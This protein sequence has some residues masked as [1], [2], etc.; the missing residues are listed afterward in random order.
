M[1]PRMQQVQEGLNGSKAELLRLPQVTPKTLAAV[2]Q[3]AR[4]HQDIESF[5]I[6]LAPALFLPALSVVRG[7]LIAQPR[8]DLGGPNKIGKKPKVVLGDVEVGGDLINGGRL[9]VL[10][11]LVVH[12][13]Y[14]DAGDAALLA[15]GGSLTTKHLWTNQDVVV[16]GDLN[17]EGLVYGRHGNHALLVG[18]TL[19]ARVLVQDDREAACGAL[20]VEQR[21]PKGWDP[22]QAKTVFAKAVFD[23]QGG[24]DPV[25]LWRRLKKGQNP[26]LIP[27]AGAIPLSPRLARLV[28]LVH[29]GAKLSWTEL[30][31]KPCVQIVLADGARQLSVLTP[32]EV[33]ALK[34]A[35]SK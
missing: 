24:L 9:V 20:A 23:R 4:K 12:G 28:G 31:G 5:L 11:D 18:R 32:P 8:V 13:C 7:L 10:G 1:D 22:E 21:F 35:I 34:K 25:E 16:L 29:D 3:A 17:C 33:K 26:F 30:E 2:A 19:R 14:E 15:V 27:T 6:D